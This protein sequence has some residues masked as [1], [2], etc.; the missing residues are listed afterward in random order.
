[1][2]DSMTYEELLAL[3]EQM[4]SVS[5]GLSPD[6]LR[7]LPKVSYSPHSSSPCSS[8]SICML[9]FTPGEELVKLPKC[10]HL[11]HCTCISRWF[12]GKKTCPLCLEEA[13]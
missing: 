5:T 12:E 1:M 2:R 8:C 4:G 7:K 13:T 9:D 11:Y 6:Q 10:Q 3:E